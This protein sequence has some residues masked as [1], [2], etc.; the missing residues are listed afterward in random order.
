[1][2]TRLRKLDESVLERDGKSVRQGG[3]TK[4]GDSRTVDEDDTGSGACYS[5]LILAAAGLTRLDLG[6]RITRLLSSI[7]AEVTTT[8]ASSHSSHSTEPAIVIESDG[9]PLNA[10]QNPPPKPE[11]NK[12]PGI[13]HA[14]GQGALGI[15]IRST[16]DGIRRLL[17]PLKDHRTTLACYAE[18]SLMRTLEGGCSVPIGVETEWSDGWS[19]SLDTNTTTHAEPATSSTTM[20]AVQSL[21]GAGAAASSGSAFENQ[22]TPASSS[23]PQQQS[24]LDPHAQSA[25][26]HTLTMRAIVVSLDGTTAVSASDTRAVFTNDEAENFGFEIARRLVE[27]G[28]EDI[29]KNINLDRSI[30]EAQGAA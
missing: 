16:D 7:D 4:R 21:V 30:I 11:P 12:E 18:R 15:E 28:A 29:L 23:P 9:H 3:G 26:P 6:H 10:R 19:T 8:R 1:M 13:L 22:A 24:D 5:A 17:G 27:A 25:P 20:E 2:G 14:V